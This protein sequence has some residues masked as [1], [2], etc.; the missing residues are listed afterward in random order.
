MSRVLAGTSRRA[1]TGLGAR[2]VREDR[3]DGARFATW[4]PGAESVSIVGEFNGWDRSANPMTLRGSTGI[5]E[6]FV[7]GAIQGQR[8]RFAIGA[9]GLPTF[10]KAD[11]YGLLCEAAPGTAS[12]LWD[13]SGFAW[14]DAGWIGRRARFDHLGH[15][16]SIYELHLGSW[17]A[18]DPDGRGRSYR[19]LAPRLA[20]YVAELG[21]THVELMPLTEH[22][23]TG[24]WGYQV[25]GY[26]APT[27]RHGT[28]QDLMFLVDHL[29]RNGIGVILD[30]VPGH[31]PR[32]PHGLSRFDGTFLY[33][34]A[35]P[36]K[37]EHGEWG[38]DVFDYQ[39]GPVVSFL[40]SNAVYWLEHYHFDGLRVD[41]V[42]SMLYLDYARQ[43]G[44]WMT[45]R[46]G[47]N[48]N[49]EAVRFLR[50]LNEA[51]H[52]EFPGVLMIAEE[53]TSWPGVTRPTDLGGLGF[54]LKWDLGWMHDLMNGYLR[55]PPD[56]RPEAAGQL[57]IRP[58]YMHDE[59]YVLPLSHDEVVHE[60]RSLLEKMPGDDHEKFSNVRLLLGHQH[61]QPGRP[62]LFMGG[63]TGQR[64]EWDHDR[65]IDWE[66]L[67]IPAHLGLRRWVRDLNEFTRSEPAMSRL[68]DDPRGIELVDPDGPSRG[69][70][71][72][73]RLGLPPDR[74]VLIVFNFLDR[75]RAD[76][77]IGVPVP[78]RWVER[79]N[80]ES[81]FYA[82]C[83]IGNLGGV[84]AVSIPWQDR[85]YSIVLTLPPL[86]MLALVSPSPIEG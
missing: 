6:G 7:T 52:D 15:P 50:L 70:L 31:F 13:L 57:L 55:H 19:E 78:G 9:P 81:A 39:K 58:R 67:E 51:V 61:A 4:A 20:D 66:V 41:A 28:P 68:D 83:N 74:V 11:P 21:F 71:S 17:L 25:T 84:E 18:P 62:L 42:A 53:S 37:R 86:G 76:E 24:S 47:G 43:P 65:G 27:N 16:I 48:E 35:D 77:R 73:L 30:W 46:Y 1:Y 49:T 44:R 64:R 63:E 40:V 3:R 59:R 5:W 60:K 29:H 14:G 82:G 8:Y 34:Y 26:Y 54:D 36:R 85:P 38:T 69:I 80:S 23:F 45:N 10:E 2:L 56:A 12:R 22:P 79:L 75:P 33:E 72:L 32:D